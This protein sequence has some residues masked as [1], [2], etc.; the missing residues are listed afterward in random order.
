MM[1]PDSQK[2]LRCELDSLKSQ[3]Q[4][5]TK[6]N[7]RAR[8]PAASARLPRP[9]LLPTPGLPSPTQA[10]EFLNHS[11]TMLEKG[12]CLQQIKIQQLEGEP[13][14]D[15]GQGQAGR[16]SRL[17]QAEEREMEQRAWVSGQG[18]AGS[19]CCCQGL[20]FRPG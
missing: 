18:R 20:S 14:A 19:C 5:Q 16:G 4:A 6:V 11:V 10:F 1:I 7:P 9:P 15:A 13:W 8:P 2:L 17:G 3:L 12:S